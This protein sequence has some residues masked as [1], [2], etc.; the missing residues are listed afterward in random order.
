MEQFLKL[1]VVMTLHTFAISAA[2][3]LLAV[4]A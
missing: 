3:V 1:A 2:V 4:V